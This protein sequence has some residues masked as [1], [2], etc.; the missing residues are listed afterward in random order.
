MIKICRIN[1]SCLKNNQD[2]STIHKNMF[3]IKKSKKYMIYKS[4]FKIIK[5]NF[6]KK[7]SV[8]KIYLS[9]FST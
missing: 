5:L 6:M 9:S 8:A 3:V 2:S 7:S 1:I 4:V